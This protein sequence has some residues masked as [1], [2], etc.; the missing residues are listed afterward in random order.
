[1]PFFTLHPFPSFPSSSSWC[2]EKKT[3]RYESLTEENEIEEHSSCGLHTSNHERRRESEKKQFINHGLILGSDKTYYRFWFHY[4]GQYTYERKPETMARLRTMIR[5]VSRLFGPLFSVFF[6]LVCSVFF[7]FMLSSGV[8]CVVNAC[9]FM[10]QRM[11][12]C[13][14]ESEI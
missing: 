3:Q 12:R 5:F 10:Q 14:R 1:M 11:D 8:F 4:A 13:V 6:S 7:N 9:S 2:Y